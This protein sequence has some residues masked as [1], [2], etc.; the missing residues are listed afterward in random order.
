MTTE[1]RP[2]RKKILNTDEII[3]LFVTFLTIGTIF[4]WSISNEKS[5]VSWLGDVSTNTPE[6]PQENP[7][8]QKEL[9]IPLTPEEETQIEASK[10]KTPT[11]PIPVIVKP[12]VVQSPPLPPPKSTTTVET[13]VTPPESTT[14]VETP[15]TPPESTTTVEEPQKAVFNDVSNDYWAFPFI[16]A[17]A[18]KN[19]LLGFKDTNFEPEQTMTRAEF[20]M[21]ITKY[22]SEEKSATINQYNDVSEDYSG[23]SAIDK[24]GKTGFL[25]GYSSELFKPEQGL[26]RLEVL[27]ALATG[28]NLQ[29]TKEPSEILKYYTDSD[30]I[31]PWAVNQIAAATE[32]GL[33]VNHPNVNTLNPQ[34]LSTKA[35]VTAMLYQ[36]LVFSGK[37]PPVLSDYIVQL[38]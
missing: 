25:K 29:P 21:E 20:A 10:Q 37:I 4:F 6:K 28:L 24:S 11:S 23:K 2:P 32:A 1:P 38:K 17:L 5:R 9:A 16:Y 36:S 19:L 8:I 13:P 30:Q 27:V 3:A 7:P 33:V 18:E 15:V 26:T 35:E 22:Y 31:P 14:T 34:Q 12:T